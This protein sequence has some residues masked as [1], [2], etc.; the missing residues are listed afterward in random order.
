[1]S[2]SAMPHGLALDTAGGVG[3]TDAGYKCRS[4]FF[5]SALYRS[6]S[7]LTAGDAKN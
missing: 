5:M 1:M 3:M 7:P 6:K 2:E 4:R